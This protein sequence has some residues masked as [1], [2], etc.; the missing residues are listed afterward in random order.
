MPKKFDLS[1]LGF[2]FDWIISKNES[3]QLTCRFRLAHGP[4][5]YSSEHLGDGRL[6][7]TFSVGVMGLESSS[8]I[9]NSLANPAFGFRDYEVSKRIC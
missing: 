7:V 4:F 6:G 2:Q 5:I 1:S 8:R 3:T 9:A